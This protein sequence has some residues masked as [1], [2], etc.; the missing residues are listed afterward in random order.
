MAG[1][2]RQTSGA[3]QKREVEGLARKVARENVT[4]PSRRAQK[5]EQ[6]VHIKPAKRSTEVP[7]RRE[8]LDDEGLA[9]VIRAMESGIEPDERVM[10]KETY[11]IWKLKE[12]LW[13]DSLR[14]LLINYKQKEWDR[15]FPQIV[16]TFR[17]TPHRVT[18]EAANMLLMGREARL[19]PRE[20]LR[21]MQE[22]R[23]MP[24][25]DPIYQPGDQVWLKSYFKS[26]G[27][28]AKLKP[29]FIGPYRVLRALP[30]QVY[31][32]EKGGR[33][34]LQHEERINMYYASE[35]SRRKKGQVEPPKND[36]TLTR[37]EPEIRTEE[38]PVQEID[39]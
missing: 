18:G 36:E 4:S 34:T 15:L 8:Q 38:Q 3:S 19:P 33:K 28:G 6:I 10:G 30:Y 1:S 27:K 12:H 29:K 32:V 25:V 26:R 24:D 2:S 39:I 17:V 13:L 7:L 22:P 9:V 14:A 11:S 31:K 21:Q 5:E 37:E 23:E 35:E 16:R 20:K